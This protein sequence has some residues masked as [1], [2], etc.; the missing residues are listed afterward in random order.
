MLKMSQDKIFE[1]ITEN[2]MKITLGKK[3]F[4]VND[5]IKKLKFT[6]KNNYQ[7]ERYHVSIGNEG[8][9]FDSIIVGKNNSGEK[10]IILFSNKREEPFF[11]LMDTIKNTD[12]EIFIE[13]INKKETLINGV[14]YSNDLKNKSLQLN[15][16]ANKIIKILEK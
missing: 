1:L 6:Q 12:L 9:V 16:L 5:L 2:I 15:F 11:V 7:T 8:N 14:D 3:D 13:A 4:N 10:I